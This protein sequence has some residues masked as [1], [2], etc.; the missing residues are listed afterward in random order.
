MA[1]RSATVTCRDT[2][3]VICIER[4]DFINIFLRGVRGKEP[5]HF[6]FLREVDILKGWPVSALPQDNPRICAYTY[7][8]Y[9]GLN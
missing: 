3:E 7:V 1:K 5:A 2:V 9:A 6:T 8:R 4:D